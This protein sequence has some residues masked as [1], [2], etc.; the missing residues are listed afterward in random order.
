MFFFLR[1]EHSPVFSQCIGQG[2]DAV[3]RKILSGLEA[4]DCSYGKICSIT[5]LLGGVA[6]FGDK[7]FCVS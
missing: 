1:K 6:G 5:E 3:N 4:V 2:T 7:A